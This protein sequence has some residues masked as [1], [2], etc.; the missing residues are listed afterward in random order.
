MANQ[1]FRTD[2]PVRPR[3]YR[4][5]ITPLADA[6][7]Q[8]LIF[9]M[10][11][12]NLTPYALLPLKSA[13]PETADVSGSSAGGQGG[14]SQTVPAADQPAL[15]MLEA[16]GLIVGGQRFGFESV[17]TLTNALTAVQDDASVS[18]IVGPTARVQ[19]M[20]TVLARLEAAGIAHV[21]VRQEK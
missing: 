14:D 10:L 15:W 11:S 21:K 8:L 5:M 4:F 18:L 3:K 13:P 2:L 20:A 1:S 16:G 6:M 17:E 7:F 9:F 12:S 19:D